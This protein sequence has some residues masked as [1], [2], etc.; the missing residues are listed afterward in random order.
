MGFAPVAWPALTGLPAV[1][2][3]AYIA[4]DW[5]GS[6]VAVLLT[7][8]LMASGE[9][10]AGSVVPKLA[11]VTTQRETTHYVHVLDYLSD[12][13]TLGNVPP[14]VT[15]ARLLRDNTPLQLDQ[16]DTGTVIAIPH[17]LRDPFDTV[18]ELS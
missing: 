4:T 12:C 15:K 6:V 7:G 10:E 14:T 2:S 18:I 11:A 9:A 5:S 16:R 8:E 3:A 17:E 13:V 1:A